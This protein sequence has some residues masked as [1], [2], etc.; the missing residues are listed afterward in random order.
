MTVAMIINLHTFDKREAVSASYMRWA[1]VVRVLA[2]VRQYQP[3]QPEMRQDT[4]PAAECLSD[5]ND[6]D[7]C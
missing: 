2:G 6:N 4:E 3:S 5:I 7:L 1:V